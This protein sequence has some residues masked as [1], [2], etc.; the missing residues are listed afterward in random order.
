MMLEK[1]RC[2]MMVSQVVQAL[3]GVNQIGEGLNDELSPMVHWRQNRKM[4]LAQARNLVISHYG[5]GIQTTC[6]QVLDQCP[7]IYGDGLNNEV[8]LLNLCSLSPTLKS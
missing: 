7:F 8:H 2:H 6:E 1:A 3:I 4:A 5:L